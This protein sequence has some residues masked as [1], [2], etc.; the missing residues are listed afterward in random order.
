[1]TRPTQFCSWIKPQFF[2]DD[3]VVLALG[4]IGTYIAGTST[5]T[6]TYS[7]RDGNT[8]NTNPVVLD[9]SGRADIFLDSSI[10]YKFIVMDADDVPLYT[11]DDVYMDAGDIEYDPVVTYAAGS[12]G[13]ELNTVDDFIAQVDASTIDYTYDDIDAVQRTIASKLDEMVS[14]KDFG[15]TGDGTTDDT[16]AIQTAM[17]ACAADRVILY[18]PTGTYKVTDS[19]SMPM[20]TYLK[21][22]HNHNGAT[23]GT[24]INFAP[25]SLKSLFIKASGTAFEDA[26]YI[27]GFMI[28]GNSTNASGLSFRA[29]DCVDII[30]SRFSNIRINGFRTGIRCEATINNRF[31]FIRIANCYLHCVFYTG[32]LATTDV[33]DQCYL[34]NAPIGVQTDGINI[35]IRFINC[36]LESLE[37]YGVNLVKEC[38]AWSFTNTYVEDVPT[39]NVSTNAVFRVGYDGAVLAS[40][41]QL[42]INGGYIAGR[43]AGAVGALLDVDYTD[44]VSLGGFTCARF[45]N[46]VKT[47]SNT[48]TNQVMA[49]G[50]MSASISTQVSDETKVT[51]LW[52][53]GSFNSGFRNTQTIQN[54]RGDVYTPAD[55]ACTG[56]IT[57]TTGWTL[58]KIANVVT[59]R[60]QAV[61]GVATAAPSFTLGE[62]VPARYRS[63][64]LLSFVVPIQDNGSNSTTPGMVLVNPST[65]AIS[66]YK[67]LSGLGNFTNAAAAG[68]GQSSSVTL[69]WTV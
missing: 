55:A 24:I 43:N 1:M 53:Y 50:W 62:V 5:Q 13:A 8:A 36:I 48:Q 37:T 69:T 16:V 31:E 68:I 3:G 39:A 44:G 27:D 18:F 21:G 45:T 2:D 38:Y 52:G 56:A 22:E 49:H 6:A 32:D 67:D 41:P 59:L 26:F 17:D 65:G 19:L 60:I 46:V 34:S 7:D 10:R 66:V 33:W 23:G 40:T 30:N 29:I 20:H 12:V 61:S 35:G 42:M 25:T 28:N 51:G 15:A 58:T 47:S 14:V 11:V 54:V 57:A 9:A 64:S 63:S 4:K